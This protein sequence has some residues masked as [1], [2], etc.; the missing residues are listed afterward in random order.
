[1]F[2]IC[3]ND[4]FILVMFECNLIIFDEVTWGP[5]RI[6]VKLTFGQLN[7]PDTCQIGWLIVFKCTFGKIYGCVLWKLRWSSLTFFYFE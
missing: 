6:P 1:M 5:K 2:C 7:A 3:Y 4:Y